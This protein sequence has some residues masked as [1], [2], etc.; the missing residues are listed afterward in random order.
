MAV[1]HGFWLS[2]AASISGQAGRTAFTSPFEFDL[3]L[4]LVVLKLDLELEVDLIRNVH[5]EMQATAVELD[6]VVPSEG[7]GDRVQASGGVLSAKPFP[8]GDLQ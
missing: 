8:L 2:F 6:V 1:P 7:V 4:A 5:L 3:E